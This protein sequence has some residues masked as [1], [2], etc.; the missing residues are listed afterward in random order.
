[1]D[2]TL[3]MV[4]R[5]THTSEIHQYCKS[6][7]VKNSLFP[8]RARQH[9]LYLLYVNGYIMYIFNMYIFIGLILSLSVN[10]CLLRCYCVH[11]ITITCN[12]LSFILHVFKLQIHAIK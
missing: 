5:Y 4:K 6:T 8:Y 2:E 12:L 9:V 3:Y 10:I 11:F 7:I 1:M